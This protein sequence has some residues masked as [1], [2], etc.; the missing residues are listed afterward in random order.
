MLAAAALPAYEYRAPRDATA[1]PFEQNVLSGANAPAAHD[2][3]RAIGVPL[4]QDYVAGLEFGG[5]QRAAQKVELVCIELD[6]WPHGSQKIV[7][8][9]DPAPNLRYYS[10]IQKRH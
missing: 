1:Y 10:S 2:V 8:G 3:Q 7:T 6:E 4:L 9:H 5:V